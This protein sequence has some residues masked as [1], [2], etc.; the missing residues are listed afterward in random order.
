MRRLVAAAVVLA[1]G[2][3]A[4]WL[5]VGRGSATAAPAGPLPV[6]APAPTAV[7]TSEVPTTPAPVTT[8]AASTPT[9][10]PPAPPAAPAVATPPPMCDYAQLAV[11]L[12][13][14]KR[15]KAGAQAT[16]TLAIRNTGDAACVQEVSADTL[17]LTV[18]SGSDEIWSTK[19]CSAWAPDVDATIGPGQAWEW[20][21]TWDRKRSQATCKVVPKTLNAGTYVAVAKLGPLTS[22]KLVVQL[23]W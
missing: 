21:P 8:A 14:P 7:Q 15:V 18:T 13:G 1:V 20:S 22:P 9:P 10:E 4:V 23:H 3:L 16:F 5:V 11:S 17:S 12:A 19:D 6:D 2:V